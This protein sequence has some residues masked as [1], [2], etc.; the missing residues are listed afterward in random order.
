MILSHALTRP[1]ISYI[2]EA[3][4]ASLCNPAD[5]ILA[6]C[7]RGQLVKMYNVCMQKR[8][9]SGES[10]YSLV[11]IDPLLPI[12]EQID[13]LPENLALLQ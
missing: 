5:A 10:I 9:A 2:T 6:P 4:A 7:T 12:T 13:T 3:I 8:A 11:H 1:N